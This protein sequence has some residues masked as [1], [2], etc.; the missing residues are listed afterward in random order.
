MNPF[1]E[2]QSFIDCLT[3]PSPA[4]ACGEAP[5]NS[6]SPDGSLSSEGEWPWMASLLKRGTHVCGG[7]LVSEDKVL[8]N[9]DCIPEDFVASEYTVVLGRLRQNGSN[10][11]E[12]FVAVGSVTRSNLTGSNIA[13][14]QL[15]AKPKL[16]DYVWPICL[17]NGRTFPEG[18]TCW[19]AG[20]SSVN[21]GA[22]KV[23]LKFQ[24]EVLSCGID[25]GSNTLCTGVFTQ[26]Q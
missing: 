20:W 9:A 6:G 24:T 25:S 10:P 1:D 12:Q 8:T 16:T 2:P 14:L 19:A 21:G 5:L 11:S 15:S 7:T 26:E 3:A 17:D 18:S 13:L 22:D 4:V 23:L